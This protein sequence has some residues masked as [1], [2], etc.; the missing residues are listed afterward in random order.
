MGSLD[1]RGDGKLQWFPASKLCHGFFDDSILNG[2]VFSE[3]FAKVWKKQE[4]ASLAMLLPSS[5]KGQD[6]PCTQG[7]LWLGE[8]IDDSPTQRLRERIADAEDGSGNRVCLIEDSLASPGDPFPA[9]EYPFVRF[10]GTQVFH[11]FALSE[12]N[13]AGAK[14]AIR[15]LSGYVPGF[16]WVVDLGGKPIEYLVHANDAELEGV[17]ARYVLAF[18]PAFDEETYVLATALG[19][20]RGPHLRG[21]R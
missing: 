2:G 12:L 6:F 1:P 4:A 15:Q 9:E 18:L 19:G 14:C 13:S 11:A 21:G 7:G 3:A 20:W 8:S 10:R 5:G 16:G 17:M